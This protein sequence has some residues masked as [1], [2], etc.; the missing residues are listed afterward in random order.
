MSKGIFHHQTTINH[1]HNNNNDSS[2]SSASNNNCISYRYQSFPSIQINRPGDPCSAHVPLCDTIRGHSI[3]YLQFHV[4]LT[5]SFG[6]NALYTESHPGKEDWHPLLA[7]SVGIG[8]LWDGARCLHYTM[9]N[10]TNKTCVSLNFR[11]AIY[12]E[13]DTYKEDDDDENNSKNDSG[14]GQ[15]PPPHRHHH[16]DNKNKN[17]KKK[18]NI[19]IKNQQHHNNNRHHNRNHHQDDNDDDDVRV[20][21]FLC[22]RAMLEDSFSRAGPGYYSDAVID[23]RLGSSPSWQMVAKKPGTPRRLMDPDYRVGF[24]FV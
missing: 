8:F 21:G 7:K 23:L 16:H 3:G 15:Y 17:N 4:P 11:I 5:P 9:E 2:S 14:G 10:T 18:N 22:S 12:R 24:P 6:T 1:N 20:G 13:D 19:N